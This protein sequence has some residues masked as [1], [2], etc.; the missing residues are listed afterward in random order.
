MPEIDE[1]IAKAE[2]YLDYSIRKY[3][4]HLSWEKKEDVKQE[5]LLRVWRKYRE[6]KE[7]EGWK[8]FIQRHCSGAVL[9]YLK[10]AA[11][12]RET[13][14]IE[15]ERDE[16][17]GDLLIN[18]GIFYDSSEEVRLP[19]KWDLVARMASKD[20]RVLLVARFILGHRITDIAK[21]SRM[22]RETLSQKLQEF[23]EMLEDP[24]NLNDKWVNQVIYAFGLSEYFHMQEHDNGEGWD[25]EPMDIFAEDLEFKKKVYTNQMELI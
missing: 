4:S 5:G 18:Y 23:Y 3:A 7:D 12:K 25:L 10:K 20:D 24:F 9:D 1:V 14:E 22:S 11:T 6:L 21:N 13:Y 17:D 2:T 15:E 19:I 16:I 8:A